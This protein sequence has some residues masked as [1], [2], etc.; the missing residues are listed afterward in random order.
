MFLLSSRGLSPSAPHQGWGLMCMSQIIVQLAERGSI[1][2][3]HPTTKV[4]FCG[5]L[6][7]CVYFTKGTSALLTAQNILQWSWS[8][9][10]HKVE[11]E[12]GQVCGAQEA[13]LVGGVWLQQ[14]KLCQGELLKGLTAAR[15]LCRTAGS[16]R[17]SCSS[18]MRS[19]LLNEFLLAKKASRNKCQSV[20]HVLEQ[21]KL[22]GFFCY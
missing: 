1:T 22:G 9:H 21:Q 18:F 11:E 17:V 4:S 20:S 8:W 16:E 19:A 3:I 5:P 12:Q 2:R 6:H 14:L 10:C 7:L 15:L 13:V